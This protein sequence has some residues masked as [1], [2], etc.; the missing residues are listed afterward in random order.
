MGLRE[1]GRLEAWGTTLRA[2]PGEG[3]RPPLQPG[4]LPDL[5]EDLLESLRLSVCCLLSSSGAQQPHQPETS[6]SVL[7][8][9]PGL[10]ISSDGETGLEGEGGGLSAPQGSL[11]LQDSATRTAWSRAPAPRA[12]R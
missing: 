6:R 8:P 1:G 9:G 4:G 3:L 5:P 11:Y 12:A 2:A 10:A 7:S